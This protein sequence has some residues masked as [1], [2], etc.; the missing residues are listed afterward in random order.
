MRP[1]LSREL[2]VGRARAIV[3]RDGAE[4]VTLRGL[5]RDLGVTAPALY[6]YVDDK[7]DLLAAVATEHFDRLVS[8]FEAI[9][10]TAYKAIK[11]KH[12]PRRDADG[13]IVIEDVVLGTNTEA[14]R[15]P[16]VRACI[17]GHRPTPDADAP[18]NPLPASGIGSV[19]WLLGDD[20]DIKPFV[21]AAQ[22]RQLAQAALNLCQKVD[23][24]LPLALL[25]RS[26]TLT[27]AAG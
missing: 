7:H 13:K 9:D 16:L 2:L 14:I 12:E 4:A 11:G 17:V 21:S 5:A 27:P 1:P 6:A 23:D 25:R 24:R 19:D 18:L 22:L 26:R 20:A 10:E 8:R 3:E 15:S